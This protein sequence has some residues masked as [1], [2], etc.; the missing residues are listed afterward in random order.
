MFSMPVKIYHLNRS[1]FVALFV[2]AFGLNWLWEML[3]MPAYVK[4]TADSWQAKVLVCTVASLIDG[5]ITLGVYGLGAFLTGRLR[6]A[7]RGEW[8]VY[9]TFAL[10]G[11]I[12]AVVIEKF[13]LAFGFWSYGDRMPIL[14]ML[15]IGLL[16]LLQLTLL[17]PAALWIALRWN[18]Q[19][20][21]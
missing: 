8:R 11:A 6:W 21:R 3:Q 14:P 13:A 20:K 16:L 18:A 7:A 2:F 19:T 5:V 10:G 4:T 9:L 17:L 15:G 1:F 12:C